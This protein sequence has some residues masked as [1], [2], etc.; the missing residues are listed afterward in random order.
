MSTRHS[1]LA[2]ALAAALGLA[3]PSAAVVFTVN[4]TNDEVDAAI[5]GV[6][7][8]DSDVCTL[9]AAVQEANETIDADVIEVP[10]GKYVLKLTGIFENSAATGDLDIT[11]SL[12]I[13]GAG[14]GVTVIQGK[15]DRVF[16]L[17]QMPVVEI[18]GLS[19][20]KGSVRTKLSSPPEEPEGGGV[21][22]YPDATL[23]LTDVVVSGN[24]VDDDGG[25]ISNFGHLTLLRVTLEKNSAKSDAGGLYNAGDG[26]ASV[27]EV[28]FAKNKAKG[29]GGAIENQSQLVLTNVTLSANKAR[30][31][32]GAINND[33]GTTLQLT[34]VTVKGNKSGSRTDA[35]G[36]TQE[37]GS[38]PLTL[39]NVVLDGNKPFNCDGVMTPEGGNLE[40]GASCG[41]PIDASNI[42][43]LG[44]AALKDNGGTTKT[45]ALSAESPAVDF[46]VDANCPA[47]DQRGETRVD[48]PAVGTS[49]CDSGAYE[50]VP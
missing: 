3:A 22:V 41:L 47:E 40:T 1:S 18:N 5:D 14:P 15:K 34:N 49:I 42:K 4:S 26:V 45:H 13:N 35:G 16:D 27:T 10:A 39:R 21:S 48:V 37:L 28:T 46:G 36:L 6:C 50:L 2:G 9:R 7:A 31:E 44:L 12:T 17:F 23:T 43:K 24:K 30:T 25:G 33:P 11:E 29:D 38:G 8:S 20:T 32:G 19:I